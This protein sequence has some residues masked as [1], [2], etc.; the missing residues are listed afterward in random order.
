[1]TLYPETHISGNISGSVT[2]ETNHHLVIDDDTIFIPNTSTLIIQPGAVIRINPGIDFTVHGTLTAQGEENNMFWITS[3]D[4]FSPFARCHGERSRTTKGNG[5]L[6]RND[7]IQIYN[8]F[9]LSSYASIS[10]D[11]IE[12]GKFDYGNISFSTAVSNLDINHLIYRHSES[13]LTISDTDNVNASNII[14]KN[15]LNESDGGIVALNNENISIENNII[16]D[17]Y[18]GIYSKFCDNTLIKNNYISNNTKGI[19]SLTVFGDIEHNELTS[20]SECDVKLAG[21]IVLGE[22]NIKYNDL[23]SDTGIWQYEQGSFSSFYTMI[24]NFNNFHCTDLFIL[25]DSSGILNDI[26]ATNNYF[27]SLNTEDE[28]RM[29][30]IDTLEEYNIIVLI[31]NWTQCLIPDAGIN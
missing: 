1:M 12:W 19:W 26:D 10:D 25:Y 9:E 18:N 16:V 7:S 30:I 5:F 11:L 15:C 23:R 28:I 20:N 2:V 27:D 13:G 3:N 4:G 31:D 29:R 6:G 21:N 14:S 17:N 8:S 22:I 24:I